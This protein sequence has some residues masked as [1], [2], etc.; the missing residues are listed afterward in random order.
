MIQVEEGRERPLLEGNLAIHTAA[1]L[2]I[3]P[4]FE[5]AAGTCCSFKVIAVKGLPTAVRAVFFELYNLT[6]DGQVAERAFE[7]ESATNYSGKVSGEVGENLLLPRAASLVTLSSL[8][9]SGRE[10]RD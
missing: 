9:S 5:G 6:H 10:L 2:T 8:A 3:G 1:L 7:E 4:K